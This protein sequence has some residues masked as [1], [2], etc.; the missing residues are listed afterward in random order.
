MNPLDNILSRLD[1]VKRTPRGYV[2]RCSNLD[3]RDKSP[4]LVVSEAPDGRV[5]IH[6]FAG[7]DPV[8]ILA[9]IGLEL[10]DLFPESHL[11]QSERQQ[12]HAQ[13]KRREYAALFEHERLVAKIAQHRIES[14]ERLDAANDARHQLAEKRLRKL[15]A[16]Y[17]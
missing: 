17:G 1:G 8:D 13:A 14:G 15:E 7:C 3:H 5:L 10:K 6:C 9:G 12:Y 11:S 2:A 16:Y 4:S